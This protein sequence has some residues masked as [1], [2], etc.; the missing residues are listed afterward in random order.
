MNYVE[1]P[2]KLNR[3]GK[4]TRRSERSGENLVKEPFYGGA[5]ITTSMSV[6]RN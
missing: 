4:V 1:Y 6:C 5:Q 3:E 2:I